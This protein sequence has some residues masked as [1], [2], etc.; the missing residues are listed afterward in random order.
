VVPRPRNR[1]WKVNNS[2]IYDSKSFHFAQR[3]D[4]FS[5]TMFEKKPQTMIV[6]E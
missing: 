2:A 5:Q 6:V 1:F 3:K 4:N